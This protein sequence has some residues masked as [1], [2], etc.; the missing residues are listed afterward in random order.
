VISIDTNCAQEVRQG[1]LLRRLSAQAASLTSGLSHLDWR[2]RSCV[3]L[4]QVQQHSGASDLHALGDNGGGCER[5]TNCDTT[6]R[7]PIY[8]RCPAQ[9]HS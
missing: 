4:S 5:P 8:I 3:S 1:K 9:E 6:R 7:F 2:F